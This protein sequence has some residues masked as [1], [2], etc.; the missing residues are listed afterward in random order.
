MKKT[1]TR[2]EVLALLQDGIDRYRH[3][4]MARVHVGVLAHAK[5]YLKEQPD[6]VRCEDCELRHNHTCEI[7]TDGVYDPDWFCADGRRKE[8]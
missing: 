8:K 7:W 4:I 3:S 1:M 5:E 6:V 2:D